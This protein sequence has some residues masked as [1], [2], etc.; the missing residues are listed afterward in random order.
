[1]LHIPY[2]WDINAEK[3]QTVNQKRTGREKK[4]TQG[5]EKQDTDFLDP[6]KNLA[7]L[8]FS[9]A[10]DVGFYGKLK[11]RWVSFEYHWFF[12]VSAKE[13]CFSFVCLLL[14]CG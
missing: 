6:R 11:E 1:L 8:F 12:S 10:S 3:G 13:K 9:V 7:K 14:I 2:S 5:K 4:E